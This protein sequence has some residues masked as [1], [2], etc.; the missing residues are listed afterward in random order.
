[1]VPYAGRGEEGR[2]AGAAGADA[3]GQRALR[4][5]LDLELTGKEGLFEQLVLADVGRDHLLD[6]PGL[7]QHAEPR[8][9]RRV[10]GDDG[11]VLDAGARMARSG[12]RE[13]RTGRSRRP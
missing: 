9:R 13:C 3:L 12:P 6:L 2:D 5:E 10:V 11:Q 1:M 4:I 8:R 7:Q